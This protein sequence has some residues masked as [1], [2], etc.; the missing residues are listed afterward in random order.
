MS[1]ANVF[2]FVF[3]AFLELLKNSVVIGNGEHFQ[4]S[5]TSR[6]ADLF[7][8][9]PDSDGFKY[10]ILNEKDESAHFR[11]EE[12]D[13]TG[14]V[15]GSYGLKD[16]NGSI[17]IVQYIADD[18]GFRAQISS[19]ERGIGVQNPANVRI[20]RL[21][22]P[23]TTALHG[24]SLHGEYHIQNVPDHLES[25]VKPSRY[26]LYTPVKMRRPSLSSD[27][28]IDNVPLSR[29][30]ANSN[31]FGIT[32]VQEVPSAA[33]PFYS[34]M[35]KPYFPIET[36]KNIGSD[37]QT[38][39]NQNNHPY[40]VY[41]SPL[42]MVE[43]GDENHYQIPY[44][45]L[46]LMKHLRQ[47]NVFN[48]ETSETPSG[49]FNPLLYKP[50]IKV[51]K[52][53]PD[54]NKVSSAVLC[55]PPYLFS[56]TFEYVNA[57]ERQMN[58][59]QQ[60]Y[61][62]DNVVTENDFPQIQGQIEAIL[63]QKLL[64]LAVSNDEIVPLTQSL[65]P[66]L[67]PPS[68]TYINNL[69]KKESNPDD[70]KPSCSEKHNSLKDLLKSKY[71]T[72]DLAVTTSLKRPL[73]YNNFMYSP[74]IGSLVHGG[75]SPPMTLNYVPLQT[76]SNRNF[77]NELLND[78][79]AEASYVNLNRYNVLKNQ[80]NLILLTKFNSPEIS[81]N[82]ILE[83]L[84]KLNELGFT[85]APKQEKV[86]LEK[87]P[88]SFVHVLNRENSDSYSDNKTNLSNGQKD[89]ENAG[90]YSNENIY[91]FNGP[92]D[93][94][95]S[96]S[97]ENTYNFNEPKGHENISSN[98]KKNIYPSN[99]QEGHD[100]VD[101]IALYTA[102]ESNSETT[103][104][105]QVTTRAPISSMLFAPNA[106][107]L[108]HLFGPPSVPFYNDHEQTLPINDSKFVVFDEI[109]NHEELK[110]QVKGHDSSIQN[111]SSDWKKQLDDVI[112]E[113]YEKTSLQ[114]ESYFSNLPHTKSNDSVENDSDKLDSR[115][116][117]IHEPPSKLYDSRGVTVKPENVPLHLHRYVPPTGITSF[118]WKFAIPRPA[119]P[120]SIVIPPKPPVL[121]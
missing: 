65:R 7:S 87:T 70:H 79:T 6:D 81:Q 8:S 46:K 110:E 78:S 98:F 107:E 34:D 13:S 39:V 3:L 82:P 29:K 35:N 18:K 9:I 2:L 41:E 106:E 32:N 95:G 43:N 19:N 1:Q 112:N 49:V 108:L 118:P 115:I 59:P 42:D 5:R 22:R 85:I 68:F 33:F 67:F 77:L 36:S 15:K 4:E 100:S 96:F 92:K 104:S 17:R 24:S 64:K 102:E 101:E 26:D 37:Y 88:D 121:T 66:F 48:T 58:V 57:T 114:R 91:T 72:D 20:N 61:T 73:I 117:K 25:E 63:A 40:D 99:E 54:C 74:Q 50:I 89:N 86:S 12:R 14:V 60:Q 83:F 119:P 103:T 23:I 27:S 56:R 53:L 109:E 55:K 116:Y 71:L 30:K 105:S 80:R 93:H 94:D 52:N 75:W 10:L 51:H 84:K 44:N 28:T 69:N 38:R 120:R 111:N 11:K 21:N 113:E 16:P 97:N 31:L 47:N 76:S 45:S 62:K 90:S